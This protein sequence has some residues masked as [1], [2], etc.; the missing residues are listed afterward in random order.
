MERDTDNVTSQ[1]TDLLLP[2]GSFYRGSPDDKNL[3]LIDLVALGALALKIM[4]VASN[5]FGT[6]LPIAAG[7]R[8]AYKK[9]LGD[10]TKPALDATPAPKGIL[11]PG[12]LKASL[13][14]VKVNAQDPAVRGQLEADVAKILQYHGWPATEANTDAKQIVTTLVSRGKA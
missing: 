7:A 12:E 14:R 3:Y 13:E 6:V 8:W 11:P 5:I 9:Y 2:N 4:E 10:D 1:I